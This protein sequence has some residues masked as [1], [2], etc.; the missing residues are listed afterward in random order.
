MKRN[1]TLLFT[2]TSLVLAAS[3]CEDWFDPRNAVSGIEIS[4]AD[5][6]SAPARASASLPDTNDPTRLA[7]TIFA[8][9]ADRSP[10]GGALEAMHNELHELFG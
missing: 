5:D 2:A 4:F 10:V 3:S 7:A 8:S 9:S 6:W 1:F